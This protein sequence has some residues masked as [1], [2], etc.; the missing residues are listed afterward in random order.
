MFKYFKINLF[1]LTVYNGFILEIEE[2]LQTTNLQN[3]KKSHT[4]SGNFKRALVINGKANS[5]CSLIDDKSV[6]QA[7]ILIKLL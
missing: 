1:Y 6:A 3:P 5:N 7:G 2:L 4:D